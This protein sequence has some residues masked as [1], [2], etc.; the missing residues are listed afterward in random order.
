MTTAKY[1]TV[2]IQGLRVIAPVIEEQKGDTQMTDEERLRRSKA[3]L[4]FSVGGLVGVL[5][6]LLVMLLR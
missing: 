1:T 2:G 3:F 5:I 4:A 6:Q